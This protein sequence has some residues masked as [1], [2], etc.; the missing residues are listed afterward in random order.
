[1]LFDIFFYYFPKFSSFRAPVMSLV[2]VHFSAPILAA[3]GLKALTEMRENYGNIKALPTQE[4]TPLFL[5]FT[6]IGLFILSGI[7]F[8]NA[9][10]S[11]YISSVTTSPGLQPY[12]EQA[13]SY[14][15]PFIFSNAVSDWTL[16]GFLSLALLVITYL[17]VNN[18]VGN[19]I[20]M[21]VVILLVVIDLWSVSSRAVDTVDKA[22]EKQPFPQTDIINFIKNEQRETGERYRVCDMAS[23][24]VNSS[25]YFFIEN[26]NGYHP[27]KLRTF[28]D[29][30][31][32]MCNG[33]TSNVT[34]PFL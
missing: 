15:A 27:A 23:P 9:F 22:I 4:K 21:T 33:S 26:I 3:F 20:F 34:H 32:V 31:D 16:I 24:T 10:E 14:L 7:I 12:G 18:K 1:M 5:F 2:L 25:A 13:L 17:F 6:A 11:S 19:A 30:M 28:Q 8:A 29:M